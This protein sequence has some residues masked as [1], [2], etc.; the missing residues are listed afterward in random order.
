M[1]ALVI[2]EKSISHKPWG[3]ER[4]SPFP[5]MLPPISKEE[6]GAAVARTT[7]C[8]CHNHSP[9]SG[10]WKETEFPLQVVAMEKGAC[11]S[12]NKAATRGRAVMV[13]TALPPNVSAQNPMIRHKRL[14]SVKFAFSKRTERALSVARACDRLC[15]EWAPVPGG[16]NTFQPVE[17]MAFTF[18]KRE[19]QN[20]YLENLFWFHAPR[21]NN[22]GLPLVPS[23]TAP[24][25]K[26]NRF[27]CLWTRTP[28][29]SQVI[30]KLGKRSEICN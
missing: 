29:S 22:A 18:P 16:S 14:H 2:R 25:K 12:R 8:I 19:F 20:K 3:L 26:K 27:V 15:R 24:L 17:R 28:Q 11:F 7:H 30:R 21:R 5:S 9:P 10:L 23:L 1:L 6:G 4:G 13:M